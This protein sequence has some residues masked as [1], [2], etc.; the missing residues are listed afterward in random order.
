L[1]WPCGVCAGPGECLR[2][3]AYDGIAAIQDFVMRLRFNIVPDSVIGQS[4]ATGRDP[5]VARWIPLL[6]LVWTFWIFATPMF[7]SKDLHWLPPT[8]ASFVVFLWLYFR[9]YYRSVSQ[10][11]WA[12]AGM[13]ALGFL[14][15]PVNPGGQSYIIYACAFIAF[16]GRSIRV[17][18]ALML[19]LLLVYAVECVLLDWPWMYSASTALMGF[20]IGM[21]N[22]LFKRNQQANA[23][24]ALSHDEVRRLAATAERERIGRDLHDLLG[25]TLSLV[26]L[27]SELAARLVERNAAAAGREMREVERVARE[28]LTQV[29]SAVS[30]MR[31]ACL[32]AELA[33]ARMLLESAGVAVDSRIEG[34]HLP[35]VLDSI[36]ALVLREAGTNIL[37]HA[38]A[39]KVRI[40]LEQEPTLVRLCIADDGR[41]G[42]ERHGNGLLGMQER[43]A[44]RGGRLLIDST[45][46]QGTRLCAELPF[47]PAAVSGPVASAA[48]PPRARRA[49]ATF[50]RPDASA[51]G[52]PVPA[53]DAVA[54][55][56]VSP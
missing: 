25:H 11:L 1:P 40:H 46:G 41:G 10:V 49:A 8:L 30:G 12:V 44:A 47:D 31:S 29:R 39:R 48:A 55:P 28:A 3:R 15:T 26:A 27:K 5:R 19:A 17:A 35:A 21:M 18:L 36:L 13:A 16:S 2:R 56:R 14:L 43:L 20:A 53:A 38:H 22:V 24:L 9:A 33:S 37:R 4:C 7:G 34:T 50:Q 32:A 6:M 51:D 23:E 45:A 52:C 54:M 42:V